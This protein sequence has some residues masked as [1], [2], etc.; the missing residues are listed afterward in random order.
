VLHHLCL[1]VPKAS[2]H[3]AGVG[4]GRSFSHGLILIPLSCKEEARQ[5]VTQEPPV[6]TAPA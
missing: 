3:T 6:T 1:G 4:W 2:Q 5:N